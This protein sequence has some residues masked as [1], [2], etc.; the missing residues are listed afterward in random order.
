MKVFITGICGFVGS[1]IA[2]G[3]IEFRENLIVYG[4]DNLSR[5]GSEMNL[6]ALRELGMDVRVAD[7]RDRIALEN[8]PR[9]DYILDCAANP[10]VL[11]GLDGG[12]ASRELVDQNLY[13]T[14]NL[15]ELCRRWSSGFIL[16][17]TSRVYSIAGLT[18][19]PLCEGATRYE[20]GTS[21]GHEVIGLS[22]LGV[23]EEFSKEPPV[24]LYGATKICSEVLALEYGEVFGFPVWINRCG[25]LA[26]AGQFGKADQGIFSFWIHSWRAARPLRYIGFGGS[27]KQVRDCLHPR[28]LVGLLILQMEEASPNLKERVVN[29]SGGL[30]NSMS[31]L[32]LS[33]WCRERLGPSPTEEF[34]AKS[35]DLVES[36]PFD[37]PWL[38]LD[39]TRAVETW[40]WQ[41]QT[42]LS[43]VLLEIASHAEENP[44]WLEKVC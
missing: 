15:L 4:I 12:E 20:L 42:S 25:V 22:E 3:L 44:D 34:L 38:V 26:G 6:Q 24:S 17:S 36:R 14:V 11:A 29:L 27:G 23:R 16:L 21:Y 1:Q 39:H 30:A 19:L 7:L 41:P 5:K 31:L 37:I 28:D 9:C 18:G 10:S 40:G 32:E 13:G 43:S 2:K 35:R 8:L 33:G